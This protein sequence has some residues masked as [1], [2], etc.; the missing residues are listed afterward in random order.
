MKNC[1]NNIVDGCAVRLE[2]GECAVRFEGCAV[3]LGECAVRLGECAV[4]KRFGG[5]AVRQ[6]GVQ[7]EFWGCSEVIKC[8][9]RRE[10]VQL[11]A[12]EKK[13]MPP[14]LISCIPC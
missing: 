2:L 14:S 4:R 11:V 6:E 7:L 3:W 1:V 9:V 8:A 12:T 5:C 10:G 13:R